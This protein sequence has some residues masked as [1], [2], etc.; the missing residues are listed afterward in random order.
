MN[1]CFSSSHPAEDEE[2]EE[3]HDSQ[4]NED[5]ADF[6]RQ[7]FDTFLGIGDFVAKFERQADVAEIDQ[8]EADDEQVID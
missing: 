2:I 4:N 7:G 5:H 1:V 8:V 6:Y 3:V